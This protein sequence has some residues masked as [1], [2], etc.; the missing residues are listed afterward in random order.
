MYLCKST[1]E[2]LLSKAPSK[3]TVW[4]VVSDGMI[5]PMTKRRVKGGWNND[6]KVPVF[7]NRYY[8][9]KFKNSNEKVI[10]CEVLPRD[11]IGVTRT[12]DEA[13]VKKVFV[14]KQSLVGKS[15]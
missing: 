12:K 1:T 6:G 8:A 10:R 5:D 13:M 15:E 3:L 7:M 4:K 14:P 11:V 2:K 9:R